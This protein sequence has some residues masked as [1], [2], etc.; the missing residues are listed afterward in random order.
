[1]KTKKPKPTA[2]QLQ[3]IEVA[4]REAKLT[5]CYTALRKIGRSSISS[6][7]RVIR[8]VLECD[9]QTAIAEFNRAVKEGKILQD[10]TN[11]GGDV[12]IYLAK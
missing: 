1:M 8:Q 4:K 2:A 6:F 5:E 12:K 10:G 11:A 7:L 9:E 3:A